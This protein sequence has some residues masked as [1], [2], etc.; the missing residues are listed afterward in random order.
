MTTRCSWLLGGLLLAALATACGDDGGNNPTNRCGDGMVGGSEQCD[1]GNTT[2]GDGCSATC[3]TETGAECGNGMVETGETCDDGNTTAGDGCSATC[4][5]EQTGGC[6]DGTIDAGEDCDDSNTTPGDGCS[7]TCTVEDGFVCTSEP[8]VCTPPNGSCAAPF[9]VTLTDDA[10]VL[11]GGGTGTTAGGSNQVAA[12]ACD[13]LAA[14]GAGPDH[15][16]QFTLTDIRDVFIETDPDGEFDVTLRL[17]ATPCDLATEISEWANE[18]GCS[19]ADTANELMYFP[20]LPPGTYYVVIDG[21]DTSDSGAYGFIVEAYPTYCG[22]GEVDLFEGCDDSNQTGGDGCSARCQ[23]EPGWTCDDAEPSVCMMD[24]TPVTPMPGDLVMNEFMAADNMSDTN[25]D[26]STTS[27]ADEFIELVNVSSKYLDLTGLT[28]ADSVIVRHTFAPTASGSMTLA[29]GMAVVV[30]GAGAPNCPGV[31]N[32]FVASTGQLG[33]NDDLDTIT[34][35]TGDA[36][37]V[38]LITH[39]YTTPTLNVSFNRSPDVTGTVYALHNAVTGAVGDFSPGLRANK[40][41][42]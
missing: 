33:L 10:G 19:D 36:T 21:A 31:T 3:Q 41:A 6:G 29:P 17:L 30:W 16:W 32:W 38:P 20:A 24:A 18:D 1:D 12:G 34:V 37:P 7:A 22:D 4:Q 9:E 25:C 39:A 40:T 35:A 26:G 8:S 2:S 15:V 27:S 28:I 42:F 5:A 13:A 23:V 11:V 14:S